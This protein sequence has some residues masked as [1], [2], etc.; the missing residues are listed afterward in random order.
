LRQIEIYLKQKY[1][2][3]DAGNKLR[4]LKRIISKRSLKSTDAK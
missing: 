2:K 1:Q 4:Y 3:R